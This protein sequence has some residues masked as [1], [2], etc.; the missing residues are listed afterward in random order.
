MCA[1]KPSDS[2]TNDLPYS[3]GVVTV[4][5]SHHFGRKIAEFKVKRTVGG[6]FSTGYSAIS[7][8]PGGANVLN[9][10]DRMCGKFAYDFGG[11]VTGCFKSVCA[12]SRSPDMQ[13]ANYFAVAATRVITPRTRLT[14]ASC[15]Q[16][17]LLS[18]YPTEQWTRCAA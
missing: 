15:D 17:H 16:H 7:Q 9:F 1:D 3:A 18:Q 2:D 14:W 10:K 11:M 4:R 5:I 8:S 6:L 12:S 13:G